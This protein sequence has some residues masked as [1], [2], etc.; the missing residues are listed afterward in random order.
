MI[1][2]SFRDRFLGLPNPLG[3]NYAPST[4]GSP[5][6]LNPVD[7]KVFEKSELEKKEAKIVKAMHKEKLKEAF[8]NGIGKNLNIPTQSLSDKSILV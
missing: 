8:P 6:F 2:I 7:Y 4:L 3:G 5:R 1:P